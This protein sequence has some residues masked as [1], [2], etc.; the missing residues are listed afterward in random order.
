MRQNVKLSICIP[1]EKGSQSSLALVQAM[2]AEP[3]NPVE[4]I[5][6][7]NGEMV[8]EL[9]LLQEIAGTD[10]RLRI[11]PIAPD[12]IARSDLWLGTVAAASG[13]WVCLVKPE[14]MLEPE[15]ATVLSF[16]EEDMPEVDALGWNH[17]QIDPEAPRHIAQSVP[18]PIQHHVFEIEKTAM[19]EA[20][21]MWKDSSNVPKAPFGLFHGAIKRSLLTAIIE[22]SGPHGWQTPLPRHEWAARTILFANKLALSARPMSAANTPLFQPASAPAAPYGQPFDA[23]MGVTAAIAEIQIRVLQ[24]LGSEW[25]GCNESFLRACMLDCALEHRQQAFNA[26]A[27]A[28][29]GALRSF[30]G[31]RLAPEFKPPYLPEPQPDRRR[32]LHG[33]VFLV[34]RFIGNATTAQEFYAV[35]RSILAPVFIMRHAAEATK[36][37]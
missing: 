37:A 27:Q 9:A 10:R 8:A 29:F 25:A 1:V 5:V 13:D 3:A 2:F 22:N 18:I 23:S 24:D 20:F 35:A 14:D 19:L 17:F 12:T 33:G 7:P 6:A 34:D 11:L 31:G 26:K 32:G 15:L 4:L 28:Y 30:G 16:V 21:F 36:A